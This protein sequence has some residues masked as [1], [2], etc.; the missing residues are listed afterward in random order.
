MFDCVCFACSRWMRRFLVMRQNCLF[1]LHLQHHKPR[2]I[3]SFLPSL[4]SL[5]FFSSFCTFSSL[6]FFSSLISFSFFSLLFLTP[7]S[8]CFL[9]F[10]LAFFHFILPF[11]L[12]FILSLALFS[13]FHSDCFCFTLFS[14]FLSFF[15]SFLYLL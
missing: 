7:V 13:F 6:I 9:S 14:F 4:Y 10:F 1:S 8:F 3:L 5:L 12:S 2:T 15:L 11:S